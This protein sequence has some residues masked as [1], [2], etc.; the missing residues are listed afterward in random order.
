MS[1][2]PLGGLEV[3][4]APE[5]DLRQEPMLMQGRL[6]GAVQ[7]QNESHLQ[8]IRLARCKGVDH[9]LEVKTTEEVMT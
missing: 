5:L 2:Q 1:R 6:A 7:G 9:I 4:Y 8:T 3:G